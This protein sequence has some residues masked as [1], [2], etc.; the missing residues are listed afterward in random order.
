MA[1][2]A[3]RPVAQEKVLTL[4]R[5]KQQD[6]LAGWLF[7]GPA[8]LF[9]SVFTVF[10]IL[11]GVFLSLFKIN[12]TTFENR[13]W[14]GLDN[15]PKV[16]G[17][18]DFQVSIWNTARFSFF[19]VII[20]TSLSLLLAVAVNQKIR[21]RTFFRAAFFFPSISSSVVISII[22]LWFFNK[23]GLLNYALSLIGINGPS[24]TDDPSAALPAIMSLNIWTTAGTF[25]VIYLAALQDIPGQLYEAASIDGANGVQKFFRIT[26]PLLTAT[27]YFVVTLGIIGTFQVFD[28]AFIISG[29]TGGPQK[30]TLTI[31][32]YIYQQAFRERNGMGLAAAAAVILFVIIFSLTL[33]QRRFFKTEQN[34]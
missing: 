29:G 20:Q 28:Q 21:G 17:N 15:F 23:F 7:V 10:P 18:E 13:T 27:T 12:V 16:L 33:L 5:Q 25:M 2:S 31:V 8:L 19:V 14:V 6:S 9:F 24:W 4:Q 3:D 1:I 32:F 22:F 30:S 34:Y 11:F 26:V